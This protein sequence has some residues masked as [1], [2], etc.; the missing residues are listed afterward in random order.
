[1]YGSRCKV[2]GPRHS[3]CPFLI[4]NL[5]A[6]RCLDPP[7]PVHFLAATLELTPAHSN[8]VISAHC[9]GTH[10]CEEVWL[11]GGVPVVGPD[12]GALH[13]QRASAELGLPNSANV[14]KASVPA[15]VAR[16]GA[17]RQSSLHW[18]EDAEGTTLLDRAR[19]PNRRPRDGTID[20]PSLLDVSSST[21]VW[22]QKPKL[23][24]DFDIDGSRVGVAEHRRWCSIN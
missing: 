3:G 19:W 5:W 2:F 16:S 6:S 21:A 17:A 8:L 10:P 22:H 11:S 9:N 1:M 20:K 7:S 12:G 23:V 4:L 14:W 13:W 15:D 24:R 18:L